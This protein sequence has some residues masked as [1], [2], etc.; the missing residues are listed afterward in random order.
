MYYSITDRIF[1]K[2]NCTHIGT[3]LG[4]QVWRLYHT[5]YEVL[6]DSKLVL[7]FS[8]LLSRRNFSKV[9]TSRAILDERQQ[10]AVQ[11]K[12]R[13]FKSSMIQ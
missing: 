12:L 6:M 1:I 4:K 11:Y 5:V 9:H 10:T 2:E 8:D 7:H 3:V 13:H